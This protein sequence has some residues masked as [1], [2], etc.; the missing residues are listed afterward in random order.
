MVKVYSEIEHPRCDYVFDFF[1]GYI[2]RDWDY[3][4]SIDEADL[5]YAAKHPEGR[6]KY[7]PLKGDWEMSPTQIEEQYKSAADILNSG[8]ELERLDLVTFTFH[9]LSRLEE[10]TEQ[11]RDEHDRFS[12]RQSLLYKYDLLDRPVLDEL[13]MIYLEDLVQLNND[14][15]YTL[16]VDTAFQFLGKGR[17]KNVALNYRDLFTFKFKNF[18]ERWQVRTGRRIDPYQQNI[19][20]FIEQEPEAQKE[21][22]WLMSSRSDYDRQVSLLYP[23]HQKLIIATNNQVPV[24]LHTSYNSYRDHYKIIEER[25]FLEKLIERPVTKNRFHYLR[26]RLPD[27]YRALQKA[28]IKEDWTMG[29]PDHN[30]FRAGTTRTFYWYDVE[31]E[32]QTSL[33]IRP[34]QTIDLVKDQ[35]LKPYK[36]LKTKVYHNFEEISLQ[37]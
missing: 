26:F 11:N 12:Y 34:F 27:S 22:F 10:Y 9:V 37:P 29:Y 13:M 19:Y 33:K 21:V 36:G 8:R 20:S 14:V 7:I 5:V 35:S 4:T 18:K 3:V 16:D 24:S 25:E 17:I 23:K 30:G 2:R 31:R 15:C 1:L 32:N 28:N 6:H